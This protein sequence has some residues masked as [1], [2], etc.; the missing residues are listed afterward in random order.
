MAVGSTYYQFVER[1]SSRSIISGY[2][3]GGRGEPCDTQHRPYFRPNANTTRGQIAKIVASAAGFSDPAT[4]QSFQDVPAGST[5]YTW[6]QRLAMHSVMSG[7]PCGS[8][9]EPCVSPGNL[10]YF[11]PN[12]NATRAQV[13]KIVSNTF[14]PTCV[15]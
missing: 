9:G 5:F 1:L 12:N 3:C 6:V 13:A 8:P 15:P 10:P 2:A 14:F 11:R 7:Y 4:G